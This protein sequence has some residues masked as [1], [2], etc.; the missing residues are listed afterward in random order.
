MLG[1][2]KWQD[3]EEQEITGDWSPKSVER[4]ATLDG[5]GPEPTTIG[6]L[7]CPEDIV[8]GVYKGKQIICPRP[9]GFEGRT[10]EPCHDDT[11]IFFTSFQYRRGVWLEKWLAG[12]QQM[13]TEKNRLKRVDWWWYL[14]PFCQGYLGEK[15]LKDVESGQC[16]RGL[17]RTDMSDHR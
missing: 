14:S 17:F 16:E 10:E 2:A 15:S 13:S 5:G 9:R 1:V 11:W 6:R 3:L 7:L 4:G 8:R 12:D